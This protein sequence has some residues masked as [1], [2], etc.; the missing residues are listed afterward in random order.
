VKGISKIGKKD[1]KEEDEE[2]SGSE[3][4]EDEESNDTM[5]CDDEESNEEDGLKSNEEE[6]GEE[7]LKINEEEGII[8]DKW[9]KKSLKK[10]MRMRRRNMSMQV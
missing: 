3:F 7:G 9:K 8:D 6:L 5:D 2:E 4:E 10:S 1:I